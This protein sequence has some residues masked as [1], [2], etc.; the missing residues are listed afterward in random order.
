MCSL[1]TEPGERAIVIALGFVSP[2]S[3]T[4]E[5]HLLKSMPLCAK[6]LAVAGTALGIVPEGGEAMTRPAPSHR[7]VYRY[8]RTVGT[9][10]W[11]TSYDF[12]TI[13]WLRPAS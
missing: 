11:C 7:H 1:R 4:H 12:C 13:A 9:L 3:E 10:G 6:V 5:F 2:I 8:D